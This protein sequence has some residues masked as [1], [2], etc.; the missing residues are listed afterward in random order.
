[1][2][3]RTQGSRPRPRTQKNSKPGPRQASADRPS[4][5]Q[6]QECWKPKTNDTDASD[7][8]KR[9]L[10]FL[11]RRPPKKK[12][13]SRNKSHLC[14]LYYK[15]VLSSCSLHWN[16]QFSNLPPTSPVFTH[17]ILLKNLPWKM[18]IEQ[19]IELQLRGPWPPGHT[20]KKKK[21]TR[22][23]FTKRQLAYTKKT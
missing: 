14:S 4:R 18:L 23:W 17:K 9:S 6:G 7:L 8:H 11:F 5:G 21:K 22:K 13:S 16:N 12:R 15:V 2:E 1:M 10:K 19:I 20:S 3:S